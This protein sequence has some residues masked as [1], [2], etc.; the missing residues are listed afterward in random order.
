MPIAI[1]SFY[2]GTEQIFVLSPRGGFAIKEHF[3]SII[4]DWGKTNQK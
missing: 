4:L 2:R 3:N 1:L